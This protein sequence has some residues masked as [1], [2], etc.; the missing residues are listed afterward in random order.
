MKCVFSR[1]LEKRNF[2]N[3]RE[4]ATPSELLRQ[5][6]DH[7][8]KVFV[9]IGNFLKWEV[10][11]IFQERTNPVI[12]SMSGNPSDNVNESKYHYKS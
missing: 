7:L 1:E 5:K 8:E 10:K 6:L 2:K 11:Q 3:L 4:R 12:N 9:E